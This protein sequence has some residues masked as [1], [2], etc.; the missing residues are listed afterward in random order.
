MDEVGQAISHS[1]NPNFQVFPVICPQQ[2]N[3]NKPFILQLQLVYFDCLSLIPTLTLRI[4]PSLLLCGSVH[5]V[6]HRVAHEGHQCR[7]TN[8]ARLS[9]RYLI[10]SVF[11]SLAFCTC[12]IFFYFLLAL[13][14]RR[15]TSRCRAKPAPLRIL[16]T[17]A[18]RGPLPVPSDS[19]PEERF[20]S[21]PHLPGLTAAATWS[22]SYWTSRYVRFF[23]SRTRPC[24]TSHADTRP[25]TVYTSMSIIKDSLKG[26]ADFTFVDDPAK[27]LFYSHLSLHT[28][29]S[30]Q[31]RSSNSLTSSAY[32]SGEYF[33][34][35][36]TRSGYPFRSS[37][38]SDQPDSKRR[39]TRSFL[40]PHSL[41]MR[42]DYL[43][44][45]HS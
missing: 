34:V 36:R 35:L 1:D 45:L 41:P 18:R 13:L 28:Y 23:A 26:S 15:R 8:H 9:S 27:V 32:V 30:T 19:P 43:Y 17:A 11:I 37:G 24:L 4:G 40:A 44:L 25:L 16:P 3:C 29:L 5:C 38:S 20:G 22:P 10:S 14:L 7:G 39:G 6:Q 12:L 21:E 33:V 42:D 31:T 2:L